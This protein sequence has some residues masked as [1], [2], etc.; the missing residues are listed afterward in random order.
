MELSKNLIVRKVLISL[1]VQWSHRLKYYGKSLWQRLLRGWDEG[2]WAALRQEKRTEWKA[3]RYRNWEV[4]LSGSNEWA[5]S[6]GSKD[7]MFLFEI[8]VD[9]WVYIF[10]TLLFC[11][12]LR[13]KCIQ[14]FKEVQA[15]P[16]LE[17]RSRGSVWNVFWSTI[18]GF[19]Q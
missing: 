3:W 2:D 13:S 10:P 1:R 14:L 8:T 19:F 17:L 16:H 12:V 6:D 5:E 9:C 18:F 11:S 7:E 15:G 4:W